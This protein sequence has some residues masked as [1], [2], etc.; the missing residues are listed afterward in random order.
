MAE[1]GDT[2]FDNPAYDPYDD[3]YDDDRFD[4]T[5]PFIR[6]TSTPHYG[7]EI[8]MQTMQHETSGLPETST[9][10][11]AFGGGPTSSEVAW[12]ATKELFPNMSSTELEV[13]YKNGKLQVKMF[14]AGKK[15]YPLITTDRDTK[16]ESINKSLPKE[17]K[18]ALGQSK[19]E[20]VQQITS[21]RRK[22]LLKEKETVAQSK[23]YKE[24]LDMLE[25]KMEDTQKELE[26]EKDEYLPDHDKI[27]KLQSKI[28]VLE[29]ERTKAKKQLKDSILAEKDETTLREEISALEDV[30]DEVLRQ[31]EKT[32]KTNYL[33]SIKERK[34][35]I[36]W[37]KNHDFDEYLQI[38]DSDPEA[39]ETKA[40]ILF[41]LDQHIKEL[42]E[43]EKKTG[44]ELAEQQ[45]ISDEKI[46]KT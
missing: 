22:Q 3:P 44:E 8:E 39:K 31:Q 37:Q 25:K 46:K 7:E 11:T 36:I 15:M 1:G 45:T 24:N 34:T 27:N 32:N 20:R 40:K 2:T 23:T 13:S 6:H 43:E 19:Y 9:A 21:D 38:P 26:E 18:K 12:V 28:R 14:G 16:Q 10:E 4:E 29:G 5:T 41:M 42:V 17:I 35:A 30:E 33:K